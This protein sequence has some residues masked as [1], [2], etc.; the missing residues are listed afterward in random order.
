MLAGGWAHH[1]LHL[2][3]KPWLTFPGIL[4]DPSSP[5]RL[6]APAWPWR[7]GGHGVGAAPRSQCGK[8]GDLGE[9]VLHEMNANS[10][11]DG[12]RR[13]RNPRGCGELTGRYLSSAAL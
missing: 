1:L 6:A 9:L 5:E 8:E 10:R 3:D 12:R 13:R 4:G 2:A 11:G 7:E